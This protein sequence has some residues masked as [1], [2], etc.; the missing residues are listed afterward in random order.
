[1]SHPLTLCF[2]DTKLSSEI[3]NLQADFFPSYLVHKTAL[4]SLAFLAATVETGNK[5]R[6][7]IEVTH[8]LRRKIRKD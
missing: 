2:H 3:H 6:F 1:M 4:W 8:V 7:V 5:N